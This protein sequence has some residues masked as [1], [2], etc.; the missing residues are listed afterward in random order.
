LV[1][2]SILAVPDSLGS[3]DKLLKEEEEELYYFMAQNTSS[4]V[5]LCVS[6]TGVDASVKSPTRLVVHNRYDSSG[7]FL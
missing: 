7:L 5:V 6:D 2:L 3:Q 1:V 4:V